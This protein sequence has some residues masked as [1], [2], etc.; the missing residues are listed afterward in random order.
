MSQ[1][2]TI[3]GNSFGTIPIVRGGTGQDTAQEAIDALTQV[4]SAPAEHVLTKDTATG[5]ATWKPLQ[6]SALDGYTITNQILDK[7]LDANSTT[8]DEVADV[9]G[10]LI[11]DLQNGYAG[12]SRQTF[13]TVSK[14]LKCFPFEITYT[15]DKVTVVTYNLGGGLEIV[16]N[17]SYTGDQLDSIVLSGDTPL[18]IYL[19]KTITY[20]FGKV[21]TVSYS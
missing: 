2:S 11:D 17:L 12:T 19:T 14:N 1:G 21:T 18:S 9:L 5:N 3:S 8:L 20:T 7:T 10:T 4:S 16:K 15:D 6:Q 13:E